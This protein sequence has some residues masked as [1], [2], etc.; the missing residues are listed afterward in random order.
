MNR[1]RRVLFEM[2]AHDPDLAVAVLGRHDEPP[3]PQ[4]GC[5]YWLIW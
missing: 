1:L 5:S 3:S 4:S 2:R